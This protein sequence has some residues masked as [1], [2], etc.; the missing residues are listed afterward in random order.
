MNP[1]SLL[2]ILNNPPRIRVQNDLLQDYVL[3]EIDGVPVFAGT[4][5]WNKMHDLL[6]DRET[7]ALA[8]I[9][10]PVAEEEQAAVASICQKLPAQFVRYC[11]SPASAAEILGDMQ[12]Q[13]TEM[14]NSFG[15]PNVSIKQFPEILQPYRQAIRAC[16]LGEIEPDEL[17][18]EIRTAGKEYF[19][20]AA[21]T[22]WTG[23]TARVEVTWINKPV[24]AKLPSYFPS[25]FEIEL[26]QYFAEDIWFYR[27]D[28][29]QVYAI[30]INY[31][32]ET[33]EGYDLQLPEVDWAPTNNKSS[34]R[35]G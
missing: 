24:N 5:P 20:E 35:D 18:L 27:E 6:I 21:K 11:I 33:L 28:N 29:Q 22:E 14:P 26:A 23:N 9:V 19:A 3:T 30:G 17:S 12:F 34:A 16:M 31:L 1:Q 7:Q 8:G 4:A 25:A 2:I 15:D 10:Y 13:L 32:D